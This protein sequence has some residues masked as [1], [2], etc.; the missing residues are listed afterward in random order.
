MKMFLVKND[1]NVPMEVMVARLSQHVLSF[2]FS[3]IFTILLFTPCF[4][5]ICDK[6]KTK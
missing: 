4:N 2:I 6:N 1:Q 3:F 5:L